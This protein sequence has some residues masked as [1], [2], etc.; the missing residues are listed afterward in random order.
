MIGRTIS[1][2]QVL[3][4]LGAGGMGEIFKAQDARLNRMVAIKV[5][6]RRAALDEER[7]R[8]FIKEAQAAS[9][10]NHPNIITIYDILSD[11]ENEY[12]V[13]EY[14]AGK[15]LTE[16]IPKGGL[17][18]SKTLQFGV[19]IAD[20]LAAAHAAGIVHRDLKPGNIMVTESGRVKILD[21]G[22][23]KMT[24]ATQISEDTETIGGAPLT[25]EGSIIGT[26]SYMSPEQAEGKRVDPRSDVF[27]FGVVL[28]E[29]ITGAKAFL[30]DSAV[31]TL[32]AILRDEVRPI[33]E[34]VDGVPPELEEV[35]VRALRKDPAQRWQSMDTVHGTLAGLRQKYESGV[36]YTTQTVSPVRKKRSAMVGA[37][38]A[39]GIVAAIGA[40]LLVSHRSKP[41]PPAPRAQTARIEPAPVVLQPPAALPPATPAPAAPKKVEK[42]ATPP[43]KTEY[44]L[45]NKGVIEMAEAKVTPSLMISEIR[46][47]K[48]KFDLSVPEV[49]KLTKAGVPEEVIEVMRDPTKPPK[50]PPPP[51][52]GPQGPPPG[53]GRKEQRIPID[54][55]KGF[56]SMG[57]GPAREIPAMLGKFMLA[58]GMP[59]SLMLM[60][61]IPLEPPA[62]MP[63]RF[64]V[65]QDL[66]IG[67]M[68]LIAKGAVVTGEIVETRS[69]GRPGRPGF[70]LLTVDAADGTKMKLR[71]SPGRNSQRNEQAVEVPGYKYKEA[72]APAGTKYIG[73]VDGDQPVSVKK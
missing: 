71:A 36:L 47:S 43:P 50:T 12:M 27:S 28:Y 51:E 59:V 64:R 45:T 5:L 39:C 1:H 35:V 67:P 11:Q 49:I 58:G 9:S 14:V 65:E 30:A 57:R 38:A 31:S 21:F 55:G 4:K 54:M 32:T 26:V 29:M 73:Y 41:E 52:P 37:M 7:R 60:D 2:Y 34:L 70:K 68:L 61:D 72:L 46:S 19:Q 3:E 20:A 53:A 8:R 18:V 40:G 48:Y 66:R 69:S 10:L 23:A 13:M 42:A 24:L 15:T 33:G 56:P 16:L 6:S 22:L 44:V 25:M 63:L 62:G 17:G